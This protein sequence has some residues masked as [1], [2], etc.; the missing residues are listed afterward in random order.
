VR[1]SL[2]GVTILA[3]AYFGSKLVLEIFLQRHWFPG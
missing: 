2:G 3:L 1:L